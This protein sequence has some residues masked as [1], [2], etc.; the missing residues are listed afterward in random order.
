LCFGSLAIVYFVLVLGS[1]VTFIAYIVWR[2]HYF[3]YLVVA[4][5]IAVGVY[6]GFRTTITCG[7]GE[8]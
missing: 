8:K 7:G 6:L 1:L 5:T 2:T 3:L 4:F